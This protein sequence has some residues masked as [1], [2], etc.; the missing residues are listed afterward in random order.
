MR[1]LKDLESALQPLKRFTEANSQLE[2]YA[3]S[4]HL[5]S[6][7]LFTAK[8]FDEIDKRTVLDLGFCLGIDVDAAALATARQNLEEADI[9][10]QVEFLLA[11]V[12]QLNNASPLLDRLKSAKFDTVIMN[13]P[14]GTKVKGIDMAFLEVAAKLANTSIYSLHKSSTREYI[15]KRA[16]SLGFKGQVLA[17][18]RYD[19]P[20]SMAFHKKGTLDI[21]VDFWRFERLAGAREISLA[22][23]VLI[24][25]I[26][27]VY[28]AVAMKINRV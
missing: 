21:Q 28:N 7:M 17:E 22:T 12:A 3:T 23:H 19:L 1:R 5:A 20:K 10:N 14:F 4:S 9:E 6:R 2:Q 15:Q 27:V 13:P 24:V 26:V 8:S 25:V 18:M 16:A 11:D